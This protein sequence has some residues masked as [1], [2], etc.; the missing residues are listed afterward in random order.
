MKTKR[1]APAR[2]ARAEVRPADA[3]R[4]FYTTRLRLDVSA[5]DEGVVRA[6]RD[7]AEGVLGRFT[8][9]EIEK[10]G[11]MR[12]RFE[13]RTYWVVADE[14]RQQLMERM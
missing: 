9:E 10:F 7:R 12:L 5:T 3:R 14:L 11:G 2:R 13:T 4:R 8:A 6:I 1:Q